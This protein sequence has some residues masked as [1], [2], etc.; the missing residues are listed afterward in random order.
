MRRT[1]LNLVGAVVFVTVVTSAVAQMPVD[2]PD[3]FRASVDLG[4]TLIELD[5]ATGDMARL[6]ELSRRVL[7]LN[8]T[9]N[10]V[11]VYSEE[12]DDYYVE[13]EIVSGRWHGVESVRIY[14][15]YVFFDDP[16]FTGRMAER[17]P[18]EPDP[19][20]DLILRNDNV[21]IA[22]KLVSVAEDP[23]GHPVPV[24]QAYEIRLL[25]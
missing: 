2:S 15:A 21:L 7:I 4:T 13:M 16:V 3:S 5:Q 9:V 11:T 10:A 18:R 20:S 24:L 8:G 6:E 22:G 14:R 23:E 12:P 1:I 25:Q 17:A 19:D